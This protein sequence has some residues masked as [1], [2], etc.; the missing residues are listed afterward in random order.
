MI[1]IFPLS[2]GGKGRHV[3]LQVTN[4][5]L[6]KRTSS[7]KGD[8]WWDMLV[9][10]RVCSCFFFRMV[11]IYSFGP[12]A[13]CYWLL[14]PCLESFQHSST[15][16]LVQAIKRILVASNGMAAAKVMMSMRQWAHMEV[17]AALKVEENLRQP[18]TFLPPPQ[19]GPS[20]DHH[21]ESQHPQK[22]TVL[23]SEGEG[24]WQK[25]WV[26]GLKMTGDRR[27]SQILNGT[28][29]FRSIDNTLKLGRWKCWF[30]S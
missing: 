17:A 13:R 30:R 22:K 11:F 15:S 24:L 2:P 25:I 7:P 10:R 28:N 5:S 18:Q 19:L 14:C 3:T 8:F 1:D 27:W 23:R 4:P 20:Q 29:G 12:S 16:S 26:V 21:H 9:P 6:G